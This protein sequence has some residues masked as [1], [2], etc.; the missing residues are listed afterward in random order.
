[1]EGVI[2]ILTGITP[3][4]VHFARSQVDHH[5]IDRFL[6]V[7]IPATPIDGMVT[8]RI[9]EIH[10]VFLDGLQGLNG[11]FVSLPQQPERAVILHPRGD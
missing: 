9:G 10:M 6:A 2:R 7:Q 8:N 11:M 5:S 1:M 3:G 4:D